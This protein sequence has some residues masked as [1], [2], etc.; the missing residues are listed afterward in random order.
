MALLVLKPLQIETGWWMLKN[1]GS[2]RFFGTVQ[3]GY[4]GTNCPH[5]GYLLFPSWPYGL[6]KGFS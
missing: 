2:V 4:L 5:E 3:I 1:Y 6:P